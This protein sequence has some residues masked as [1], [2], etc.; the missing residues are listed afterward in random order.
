MATFEDGLTPRELK[1]FQLGG[2]LAGA[3][4]HADTVKEVEQAYSEGR[5]EEWIEANKPK[6]VTRQDRYSGRN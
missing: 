3:V 5:V 6:Q 2:K 1:L 4:M